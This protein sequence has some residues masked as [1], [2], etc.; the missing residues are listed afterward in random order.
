MASGMQEKQYTPSLLSFFI[1]NPTFGPREG[2]VDA[3]WS[4]HFTVQFVNVFIFIFENICIVNKIICV[5][6][7]FSF[8][9]RRRFCFTIRVMWRR[10]RRSEMWA[11]VKPLSSLQGKL[12]SLQV[13]MLHQRW[14][15]RI[16]EKGN[17]MTSRKSHTDPCPLFSGHSVQQNQLSPFTHRRTASFSLNLK[18]IFG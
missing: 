8:R 7:Y 1:Y 12:C 14:T 13:K 2:E 6:V 17:I 5:N 15:D 11:S 4:S 16:T 10:M 18:T 9:K 3:I